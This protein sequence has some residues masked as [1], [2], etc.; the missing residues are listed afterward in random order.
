MNPTS[1]D[2]MMSLLADCL[3]GPSL[4]SIENLRSPPEAEERVEYLA[5]RA[6]EGQLT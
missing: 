1:L 2:A 6:N 4:E 3:D 5:E